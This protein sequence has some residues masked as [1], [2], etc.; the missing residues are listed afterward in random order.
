MIPGRQRQ[1]RTPEQTA[2]A[3]LL[4]M[5]V[6]LATTAGSAPDRSSARTAL[7][8]DAV[9][10]LQQAHHRIEGTPLP[11]QHLLAPPSESIGTVGTRRGSDIRVD[12]A[13]LAGCAFELERRRGDLPPPRRA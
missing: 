4:L 1:T 7:G 12:L 2:G 11:G 6:L 10:C 13:H 8:R 5:V 3:A 9:S